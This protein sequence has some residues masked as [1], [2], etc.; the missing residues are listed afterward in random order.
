M[1]LGGFMSGLFVVAG[2][3]CSLGHGQEFVTGMQAVFSGSPG[4]AR[5]WVLL[6]RNLADATKVAGVMLFMYALTWLLSRVRFARE[7][8]DAALEDFDCR[9]HS[10]FNVPD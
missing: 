5:G 6:K 10:H 8:E 3:I 4:V 1:V 7:M 9:L 2:L